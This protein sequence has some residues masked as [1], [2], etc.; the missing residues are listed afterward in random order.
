MLKGVGDDC[1]VSTQAPGRVLLA[2]TDILVE[3]RHFL[4]DA[5][6]A[7]LLGKR[8]L[9]VSLSDI[10][11]MGGEPL[12]F[13]VSIGLPKNTEK[14]FVDEL[15]KGIKYQAKRFS[16][17]LAGGNT[18]GS[19]EIIISTTL[20]G[21]MPGKEVLYRHGARPGDLLF[22]TGTLGGSALGLA[23]LKDKGFKRAAKGPFKKEVMKHLDPIP[24]LSVGRALASKGLASS[25]IDISDGLMLDLKR[26]C[27][28]S[29]VGAEVQ[30]TWLPVSP[31]LKRLAK[32]DPS[33]GKKAAEMALTGG[34]E[35]ELLF[36]AP[37]KF[38][39]KIKTLSKK[40]RVRITEIGS[41]RDK[42][43]KISVMGKEGRPVRLK[44]TGFE[45]F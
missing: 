16:T 23:V 42:S 44:K 19:K 13:L 30:S 20:F 27:G 21:E 26:L 41:I 3:G 32:K 38:S 36:T 17:V 40:L 10:A 22:V 45:H 34:E 12:F 18:S 35:Y 25:M 37:A 28:S 39:N 6:P 8:A 7:R 1:S 9:C 11:A 24:R 5:A 2:T 29:G 43:Q 31:G 14:A 15:Y 33:W 4:K